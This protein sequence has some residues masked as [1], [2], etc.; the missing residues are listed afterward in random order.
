MRLLFAHLELQVS[1]VFRA[2]VRKRSVLLAMGGCTSYLPIT[3]H[4]P[5]GWMRSTSF[6]RPQRSTRLNR[7]SVGDTSVFDQGKTCIDA[8]QTSML[9]PLLL[10][11]VL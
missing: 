10:I 11:T 8:G 2:L 7:W 9:R 5:L 3:I 6:T 1:D 4:M